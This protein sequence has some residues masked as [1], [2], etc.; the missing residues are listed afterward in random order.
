MTVRVGAQPLRTF[1]NQSPSYRNLG[2]ALPA[3][4]ALSKTQPL[5][6]VL[7]PNIRYPHRPGSSLLSVDKPYP[8]GSERDEV[9]RTPRKQTQA[10]RDAKLQCVSPEESKNAQASFS[11]TLPRKV[12]IETPLRIGPPKTFTKLLQPG[13]N[14]S[15]NQHAVSE[16]IHKGK[17]KAAASASYGPSD[18][19]EEEAKPGTRTPGLSHFPASHHCMI[20]DAHTRMETTYSEVK[21]LKSIGLGES[22]PKWAAMI[23]KEGHE[24]QDIADLL[25]PRK[26]RKGWVP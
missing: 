11:A 8:K 4:K 18:Q 2:Q 17:G 23:E 10:T 15:R 1:P 20:D 6:V 12:V 19:E 16:T 25:S 26:K 22:K 21:P 3:L 14:D 5:A 13:F 7:V 24:E 9:F